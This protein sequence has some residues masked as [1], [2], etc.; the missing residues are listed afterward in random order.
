MNY[1]TYDEAGNLT[2]AFLQEL[3]PEH[4][5][6]HIEVTEEQR[7]NWTNYRANAVRDGVEAIAP[8]SIDLPALKSRLI[9]E[10]DTT[11]AAIYSR[12]LRFEAAYVAREA[13]A[14]EFKAGGYVG[15]P[16]RWVTAFADAAAM[17]NAAATDLVI[18]Q[19]DGLRSA[20]EDLDAVR[21]DKY[22]I[23]AAADVG[24]AQ[25]AHDA[26]ILQ[27]NAIASAL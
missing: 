27:A 20:L 5:E 22:R 2:G 19:A 10:V 16:G 17:T 15:D 9:D 4:A 26:I 13:A 24:S 7:M 25:A 1:V 8:I 11:I 3:Q 12:W 23:K 18:S 6:C 21:M 14:R